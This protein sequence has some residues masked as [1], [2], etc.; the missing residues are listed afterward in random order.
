MAETMEVAN[1]K[2]D[3]KNFEL[4]IWQWSLDRKNK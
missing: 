2:D 3:I 4:K 1:G